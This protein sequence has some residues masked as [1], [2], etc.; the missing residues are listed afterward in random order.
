[1]CNPRRKKD[2]VTRELRRYNG[3]FTSIAE[4]KVRIVEEFV[5]QN[6]RFSVGYFDPSHASTKRWICC[7]DDLAALYTSYEAY[8][9]KQILLWCEGCSSEESV[10]PPSCKRKKKEGSSREDLESQVDELTAE[11]QEM[12]GDNLQLSELQ[13]RL[14]ARMIVTG[15]Y[16]KKD[17]PRQVPMIT[18]IA[19]K[20][21]SKGSPDDRQ[22]FR[23][24][25]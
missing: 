23:R 17:T 16:L 10:K 20:R 13:Y 6:R 11:L 19:P 25:L 1:M 3:R 15:V 8:P 18:G 22:L 9:G 14:W 2:S 12:H 4:I 21:K 24:V 7:E 5:P